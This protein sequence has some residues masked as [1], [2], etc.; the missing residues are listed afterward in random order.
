MKLPKRS[1]C[2]LSWSLAFVLHV[3]RFLVL[4]YFS[5]LQQHL[6][7]FE[8]F[9]MFNW[10]YRNGFVNT[11]YK[12]RLFSVAVF[13]DNELIQK[14]WQELMA[15]LVLLW[16]LARSSEAAFAEQVCVRS[17]AKSPWSRCS[18]FVDFF[19][20]RW[21][22]VAHRRRPALPRLLR[23]EFRIQER[24]PELCQYDEMATIRPSR[25]SSTTQKLN[26]TCL[27][28][29]CLHPILLSLIPYLWI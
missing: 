5:L 9:L 25:N 19:R 20:S 18:R 2:R 14:W 24:G 3:G 21:V 7:P 4:F 28:F 12:E 10:I 6:P 8:M 11:C 29:D 17:T 16:I 26:I 13:K 22:P 23:E 1:S 27:F 15:Y